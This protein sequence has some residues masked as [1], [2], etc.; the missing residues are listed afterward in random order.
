MKKI[1]LSMMAVAAL[2][3]C[4]QDE[5]VNISTGEN[6][7]VAGATTLSVDA[8]T[9]APVEGTSV[10]GLLA[11]IP[12]SLTSGNYTSEYDG[13]G[14][15]KFKASEAVGFC[16]NTGA[17]TPKYY[18]ADET[19]PIYLCGLYPATGWT[20]SGENATFTLTG[21]ADVMT[22]AEVSTTK[23]TASSAPTLAFQHRLTLLRIKFTAADEDNAKAWGTIS[24]MVLKKGT[25]TNLE[26]TATVTLQTGATV[27]TGTGALKFYQC[28]G[29]ADPTCTDTEYAGQTVSTTSTYVAYI[30]CPPVEADGGEDAEY[31]LTVTNNT[32]AS[33]D[34]PINLKTTEDGNFDGSTA[35]YSFDVELDFKATEIKAQA[36]I[37]A[38][39]EGGQ[40]E[41]PVGE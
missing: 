11:R 29:T 21:G 30:L 8:T 37:T 18:P 31:Q 36:T 12:A 19:T 7:I 5:Q 14:F 33:A 25:G 24:S 2:A 9:K 20:V 6:E 26:N 34:V 38:W 40:T 15:M 39:K 3:S 1:L 41:V 16:D 10:E 32:N 4:S 17:G 27:F 23:A 35:G 13:E 22:A 28:S